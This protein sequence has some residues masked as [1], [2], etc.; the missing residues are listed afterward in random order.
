MSNYDDG[1]NVLV[2]FH[3]VAAERPKSYKLLMAVDDCD[4]TWIPKSQVAHIDLDTGEFWIP[5]WL[6]EE[7]GFD[8][9]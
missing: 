3:D 2:R 1:T 4:G 5:L 6:A 7:K 8:Y 9:E